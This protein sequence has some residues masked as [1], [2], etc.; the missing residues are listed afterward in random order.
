M[1]I[2]LSQMLSLKSADMKCI[3]IDST[4]ES[5]YDAFLMLFEPESNLGLDLRRAWKN[6]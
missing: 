2:Y 5:L 1:M 6:R 4:E 3:E